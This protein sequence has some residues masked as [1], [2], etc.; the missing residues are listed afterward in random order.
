MNNGYK[1]AQLFTNNDFVYLTH[2]FVA[3]LTCV[4]IH[5]CLLQV[6]YISYR[7]RALNRW[8]WHVNASSRSVLD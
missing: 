8:N 2:L 7:A 4:R 5:Y 3:V 1:L 6:I